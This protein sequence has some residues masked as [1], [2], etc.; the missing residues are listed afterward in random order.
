MVLRPLDPGLEALVQRISPSG[1]ENENGAA[2][3]RD[4]LNANRHCGSIPRH[5]CWPFKGE[6]MTKRAMDRGLL[7]IHDHF[8]S[9][10]FCFDKHKQV[11]DSSGAAAWC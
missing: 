2:D 9:A 6:S 5:V 3:G 1:R 10:R 8:K 11:D 7:D 4:D